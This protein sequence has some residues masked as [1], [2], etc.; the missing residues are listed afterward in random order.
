MPAVS[1]NTRR[2]RIRDLTDF[3]LVAR[4]LQSFEQAHASASSA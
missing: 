4:A 2:F 1:L 3:R